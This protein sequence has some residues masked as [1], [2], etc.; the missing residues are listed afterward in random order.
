MYVNKVTLFLLFST[1]ALSLYSLFTGV[2][3]I[4]LQ[5]LINLDSHELMV[6]L[7]SRLPRTI[8][9]ILSGVA[10]AVAGL[11]MQ[12]LC[13]N[14]FVS[15]S[16]SATLSSAQFG[17]L[18]AFIFLPDS[19]LISRAFFAFIFAILGTFLF[20]SFILKAKFKDIIM[21]PL[22]GIMFANII[23]GITSFL[24]FKFEMTQAMSSVLVGHFSTI[25]KG[26]YEIVYIVLPLLVITFLYANYFNIVGLGKNFAKNLGLNYNFILFLGLGLCAALSA[27]VVVVVGTISYIGLIVPNLIA[28][29]KGDNIKNNLL[30]TALSGALFVLICD[31]VAR[32][33]IY[34]YELAIDLITG[35][36]GSI[37]FILL[38]F[39]KL[40]GKAPTKNNLLAI[41][42][43]SKTQ[44]ACSN[45]IR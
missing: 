21:V 17:I 2:I 33:I 32:K 8:A 5:S 30:D 7:S 19:T 34:P 1:L 40:H 20:V 23:G 29:Y 22:I 39:Y 42:N 16:T 25:V 28:I 37:I 15:P 38:I 18:I 11:I 14:K 6:F 43:K 36:V 35:I 45:T 27:S 9:L 41:F 13:M 31:L 12:N 44:N 24:A 4:N 10:L 26:N 3:E